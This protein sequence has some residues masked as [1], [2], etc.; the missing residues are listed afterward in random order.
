VNSTPILSSWRSLRLGERTGFGCGRR[1]R[2]TLR[3]SVVTICAKPNSARAPGSRRG[4]A[5]RDAR[6]ESDCAKRTQFR[7]P[8][9]GRRRANAQNE[10]NLGIEPCETNP[11]SS[12]RGRLT[13]EIVQ[14]EA[15][16]GATGVCGKRQ[17]RGAWLARGVKCAKRTQFRP[18]AGA[19][20]AECAKR[21]QFGTVGGVNAQNKP[22]LPRGTDK[23]SS[24]WSGRYGKSDGTR[25]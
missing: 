6:P 24:L 8:G 7:P 5:G 18:A 14:N 17:S 16:P 9:G 22:N 4:P 11:I 12:R 23:P 20:E 10:P 25:Y 1:P 19:P 13:E 3:A 2:W 21:T 15:K